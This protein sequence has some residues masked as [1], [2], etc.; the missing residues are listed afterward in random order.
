M[1]QR[2]RVLSGEEL[3]NSAGRNANGT[4]QRPTPAGRLLRAPSYLIDL[5]D[6]LYSLRSEN[7]DIPSRRHAFHSGGQRKRR[8]LRNR[9]R[10]ARASR[11][12][13]GP[14]RPDVRW[15]VLKIV[16]RFHRV[17]KHRHSDTHHVI[18]T[19]MIDYLRSL[20]FSV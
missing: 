1:S 7:S 12:R 18:N 14:H 16:R 8:T 17:S 13:V 6:Q 15:H 2:K 10:A 11:G 20:V 4:P 9:D 19:V 3:R 5:L